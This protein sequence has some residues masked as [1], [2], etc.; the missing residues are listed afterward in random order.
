MEAVREYVKKHRT[1]ALVL[2]GLTGGAVNGLLGAGSG[3]VFIFFLSFIYGNKNGKADTETEEQTQKDVFSL[4]LGAVFF[5]TLFSVLFYAIHGSGRILDAS[6][7]ILPAVT[8]GLV[9]AV[10]LSKINATWLKVIF[11]FVIIYSGINML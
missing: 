5:I 8:G 1:A 6:P 2:C 9:G 11:A 10:L 3:I 4:S 7:Y